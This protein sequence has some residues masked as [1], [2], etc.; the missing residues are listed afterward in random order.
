M[1]DI[2]LSGPYTLHYDE[3]TLLDGTKQLD[4]HVRYWSHITH[5]V[6][7]KFLKAISFGHEA[8]NTLYLEITKALQN[9]GVPNSKLLSPA[10]DAQILTEQC[11]DSCMKNC[12]EYVA[13]LL[14]IWTHVHSILCTVALVQ[15]SKHMEVKP[16][17]LHWT[18]IPFL[19]VQLPGRRI[20]SQCNK[21][22]MLNNMYLYV[23]TRWVTLAKVLQRIIQQMP[24]NVEMWKEFAKLDSKNRPQS[25]AYRRMASK[26]QKKHSLCVQ[27]EFIVSLSTLF[28][29][30]LVFFQR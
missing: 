15:V 10:S 27:L 4:L 6:V 14:L 18:Y 28:E 13:G 23:P 29:K 19:R 17:S 22:S 5:E 7:V 24:V 21:H 16:K 12:L 30:Y 20:C 2:T 25:E 1:K 3:A 11:L 26:L 9:E 8:G